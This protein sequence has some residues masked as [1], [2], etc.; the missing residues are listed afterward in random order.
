MKDIRVIVPATM[1]ISPQ[2]GEV[3]IETRDSD[4]SLKPS[5]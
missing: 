5:E 3:V 2:S 1:I 4:I